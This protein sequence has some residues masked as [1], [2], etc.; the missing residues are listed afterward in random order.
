MILAPC[1][2]PA[3]GRPKASGEASGAIGSETDQ[4]AAEP[5]FSYIPSIRLRYFWLMTFRFSLIVV[6]LSDGVNYNVIGRWNVSR[7]VSAGRKKR[8]ATVPP[9]GFTNKRG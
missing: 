2:A 8:A 4:L 1:P 3:A 9:R 6:S 5:R 7:L